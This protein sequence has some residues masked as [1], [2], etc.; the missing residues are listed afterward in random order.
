MSGKKTGHCVCPSAFNSTKGWANHLSHRPSSTPGHIP[1]L[2]ACKEVA[3]PYRGSEQPNLLLDFALVLSHSVTSD[4]VT[5]WSVARQ[6]PLSMEFSG[7]GY[8][9]LLQG[10]FPTQGMNLFLLLSRGWFLPLCRLGSWHKSPDK[11]LAQLLVWPLVN[12]C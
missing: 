4:S 11:A 8:H 5:P 2:I 12:F 3:C 6:A 10:I 7:V 9:F 1:T